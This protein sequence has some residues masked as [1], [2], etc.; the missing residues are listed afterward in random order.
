MGVDLGDSDSMLS[1]AE[2]IDKNYAV[3]RGPGETKLALYHRAAQLGNK[4]AANAEQVELQKLGQAEAN[5]EIQIQQAKIAGE[6]FNM[7]LQGMSRR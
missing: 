6:V 5:R 2:M 1:L 3:P 4:A 7:I